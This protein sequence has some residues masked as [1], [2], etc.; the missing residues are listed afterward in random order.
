[1]GVATEVCDPR[2][3]LMHVYSGLYDADD[4]IIPYIVICHSY[5]VIE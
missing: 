3:G 1:M 2:I 5:I 4:T